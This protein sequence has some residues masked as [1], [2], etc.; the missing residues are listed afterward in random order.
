MKKLLSGISFKSAGNI[1]RTP[2]LR[3]REWFGVGVAALSLIGAYLVY[4]NIAQPDRA[5]VRQLEKECQELRQKG[6]KARIERAKIEREQLLY[7]KAVNKLKEF[8]T[9]NFLD[10]RSGQ[11]ALIDEVNELSRRN[12]VRLADTVTFTA[13]DPQAEAQ[14]QSAENK[15]VVQTKSGKG[16][17]LVFPTFTVKFS[18]SGDYRKIRTFVHDLETSRQFLV[19]KLLTVSNEEKK[20]AKGREG[21]GS[22]STGNPDDITLDLEL[23]AFYRR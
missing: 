2:Y 9:N 8:E 16:R 1:R 7:A 11:L 19:L 15:R 22:V 14:A 4:Q 6:E 17:S 5:K 12:T 18:I 20:K 13:V 10:Q 21:F 23:T 3:I